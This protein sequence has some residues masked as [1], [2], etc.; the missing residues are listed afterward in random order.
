[1]VIKSHWTEMSGS[2]LILTGEGKHQEEKF[3]TWND[4]MNGL[5]KWISA[6]GVCMDQSP[7][8]WL[9]IHWP[10]KLSVPLYCCFS[11]HLNHRLLFLGK[12][13]KT[14]AGWMYTY[15]KP[16]SSKN[17]RA[18]PYLHEFSEHFSFLVKQLAGKNLLSQLS[19]T[20]KQNGPK[21]SL[22]EIQTLFLFVVISSPISTCA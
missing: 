1:M 9:Q 18:N 11:G 21:L 5:C 20:S 3:V 4:L 7:W 8:L 13:P 19:Q 10:Q 22:E 17:L 2:R 14:L 16:Y 15:V 12:S 6:Y